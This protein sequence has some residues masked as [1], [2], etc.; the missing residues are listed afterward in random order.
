LTVS[1]RAKRTTLHF[2]LIMQN[3]GRGG[4]GLRI[5]RDAQ[6]GTWTQALALQGFATGMNCCRVGGVGV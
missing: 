6:S 5:A 4:S 3:R 2:L 1:S